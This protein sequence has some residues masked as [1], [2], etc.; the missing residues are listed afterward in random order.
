MCITLVEVLEL[1]RL[2][3]NTDADF[4][5]FMIP[6]SVAAIAVHTRAVGLLFQ[7]Y[8][9]KVFKSGTLHRLFVGFRPVMVIR[10]IQSRQ[11]TFLALQSWIQ[12]PFSVTGPSL[13]QSLLNE[14]IMLPSLL[15]KIDSIIENPQGNDSAD[16]NDLLTLFLD[17]FARLESWGNTV[18]TNDDRSS[19][20]DHGSYTMKGSTNADTGLPL[21]YPNITMA[22]VLTHLWAFQITCATEIERLAPLALNCVFDTQILASED[23]FISSL[24]EN[25]GRM[26]DLGRKIY[27]SMDY[28]LQDEMELFG[29]ASTFYPLGVA[30][31]RFKASQPEMTGDI[32]C[33]ENIVERLAQKGLLASRSIILE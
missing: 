32:A 29:P 20:P 24:V 31:K 33:I 11:P 19:M 4:V 15:H 22:N 17:L 9:P 18:W 30:Y 5:K 27:L 8:N 14:V 16:I 3:G 1:R 6:D 21:W 7:A 12:I 23:P 10:A 26:I 28:L 25:K 2:S 13:M